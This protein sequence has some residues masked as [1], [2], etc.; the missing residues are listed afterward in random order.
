MTGE[1]LIGPAGWTSASVR[2]PE[3]R[4]AAALTERG[5]FRATFISVRGIGVAPKII[6]RTGPSATRRAPRS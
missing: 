1:F 2:L 4:Q 3:P 5:L 6:A